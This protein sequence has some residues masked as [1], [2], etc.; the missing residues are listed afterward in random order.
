MNL[1]YCET[2]SLKRRL[3]CLMYEA[4]LLF[5]VVFVA[6][7]L[8]DLLTSSRDPMAWRHARQ[9]WLFL[10]IGAYFITCWRRGGQTL[11][12]KTWRIKLVAPGCAKIPFQK[13]LLRYLLGW[14]W[15]L[16]AT[17]L[18]FGFGVKDRLAVAGLY[19]AGMVLW[20]AAVRLDQGRQFLH[21]RLAGTR[22][23]LLPPPAKT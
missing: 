18:M 21:D 11:A 5:G 20:A 8:F 22:L 23:V 1:D 7:L 14:M 4:M 12:M 17:A 3:V 2:P 6:G 15:F 10:A 19:A 16:P 13:T 9:L